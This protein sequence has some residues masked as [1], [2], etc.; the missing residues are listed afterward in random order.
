MTINFIR[1]DPRTG[2]CLL[3]SE[4]AEYFNNEFSHVVYDELI[5]AKSKECD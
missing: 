2:I 5:E 1:E 4:W 3:Y